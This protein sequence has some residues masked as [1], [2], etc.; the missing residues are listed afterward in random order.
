MNQPRCTEFQEAVPKGRNIHP[1]G[2]QSVLFNKKQ[3]I[4]IP[5][6]QTRYKLMLLNSNYKKPNLDKFAQRHNQLPEPGRN[7][8]KKLLL[9]YKDLFQ[10]NLGK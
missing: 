3:E 1:N 5:Q 9:E 8:L 6:R 4:Y 10:G 7:K 2:I